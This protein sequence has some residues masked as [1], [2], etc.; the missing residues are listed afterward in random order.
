MFLTSQIPP[1]DDRE[2]SD[3][4]RGRNQPSA[5]LRLAPATSAAAE[6]EAEWPAVV[7]HQRKRNRCQ[8]EWEFVAALSDQSIL[9]VNFHD[10]D[11]HF[12]QE[13][14]R[15]ET[16]EQAE[17]DRDPAKKFRGRGEIG[18]PPR[19]SQRPHELLVSMES[20]KD[21]LIAVRNHDGSKNKTQNQ[22]RK[23]LQTVERIQAHLQKSGLRS[24]VS[25]L[26]SQ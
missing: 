8:R 9:P 7:A 3:S 14:E 13:G 21:F 23:R 18:H 19:D 11:C 10:D 25:G 2:S 6:I 22:E 4:D 26:R 15:D 1:G 24:Q 5:F 17:Y 12:D 20:A 16:S